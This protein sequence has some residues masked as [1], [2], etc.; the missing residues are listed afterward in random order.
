MGEQTTNLG[1]SG[2]HY[3]S[4]RKKRGRAK[5]SLQ[6][7]LTPM[8]DVVFQLLIYFLLT[9]FIPPEGRI[10]GTLPRLGA[11]AEPTAVDL[12]P[13]RILIRPTDVTRRSV[14][15]EI[16]GTSEPIEEPAVLYERL[17]G[18]RESLGAR[19]NEVPIII[20][21]RQDVKWSFVLE[22]FNQAV[23]ARFKHIGWGFR[24]G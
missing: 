21:P 2:G 8:I 14:S 12:R 5:A 6:L 15:Y 22:A 3:V 20:V 11:P 1:Q 10:P 19:G 24:A 9:A 13:I 23:R 4:I 16:Q 18:R 7:P 17:L